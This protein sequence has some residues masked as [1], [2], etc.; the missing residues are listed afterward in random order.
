MKIF[1]P[2]KKGFFECLAAAVVYMLQSSNPDSLS[3]AEVDISGK[4]HKCVF[5]DHGSFGRLSKGNWVV[6]VDVRGDGFYSHVARKISNLC[7]V[8]VLRV[9]SWKDAV[10]AVK[11]P[12]N[13]PKETIY[14]KH[15]MNRYISGREV[16]ID[17]AVDIYLLSK[18]LWMRKHIRKII[19]SRFCMYMSFVEIMF[20]VIGKLLSLGW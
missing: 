14:L 16:A 7:D 20:F 9:S 19:L 5:I 4:P 15:S 17:N 10:V 11:L 13:I 8:A 12:L 6:I 3:I 2:N 1:K 18:L